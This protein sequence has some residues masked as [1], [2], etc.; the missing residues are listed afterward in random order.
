MNKITGNEPAMPIYSAEGLPSY[1]SMMNKGYPEA[2]GLT[3]RQ[4][5]AM[6][7]MQGLLSNPNTSKQ[8]NSQYGEVKAE[9]GYNIIASTAIQIADALI[10]ELN[11]SEQ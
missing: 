1:T 9:F 4:Q 8:V 5:F 10:N 7:A 11:K 2:T 3:I 6:A